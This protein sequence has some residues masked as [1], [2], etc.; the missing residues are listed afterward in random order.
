M[1]EEIVVAGFGGQGV[2]FAGQLLAHA[3]M[4]ND[5]F[6]TCWPSYGPE[7]RG[8]TASSSVVVSDQEIG[9]PI[10]T[11]PTVCIVMNSPSLAKYQSRVRAEGLLVVNTSLAGEPFQRE[12]ILTLGI[13][14]QDEAAALGNARL[15]NVLLLGAA[16]AVR[17]FLP[18]DAVIEALPSMLPESRRHLLEINRAAL[19]RGA[20]LA[21][22]ARRASVPG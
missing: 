16:V 2:V 18:L 12:G 11:R 5:L 13:Q 10:V 20:E 14:A 15:A 7:M 6:V 1:Q 8:G 9:S 17:G 22:R 21:E 3:A 19:R 4:E